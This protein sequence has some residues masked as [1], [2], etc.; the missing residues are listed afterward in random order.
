LLRQEEQLGPAANEIEYYLERY[1]L[2]PKARNAHRTTANPEITHLKHTELA[3][4]ALASCSIVHGCQTLDEL[5]PVRTVYHGMLYDPDAG[6]SVPH[7]PTKGASS[8]VDDAATWNAFADFVCQ[9][10]NVA[11]ED[12]CQQF[13]AIREGQE[14]EQDANGLQLHTVCFKDCQLP[15]FKVTSQAAMDRRKGRHQ[16][17]SYIEVLVGD[18]TIVCQVLWFGMLSM[19]SAFQQTH[20]HVRRFAFVHKP[21]SQSTLFM[22]GVNTFTAVL[23]DASKASTALAVPL[24]CIQGPLIVLQPNPSNQDG[25]AETYR[26]VSMPGK[27]GLL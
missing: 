6:S 4:R 21:V 11:G 26:F 24:E 8:L 20:T 7:F 9:H 25:H 13:A 10:P 12:Y 5:V 23:N 1:M 22:G 18:A 16:A 19:W 17:S 27:H 15:G 3:D 14:V 2:D